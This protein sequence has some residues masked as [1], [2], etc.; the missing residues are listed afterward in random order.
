M[1][2]LFVHAQVYANTANY[3]H[4]HK[5]HVWQYKR[6]KP[7]PNKIT[8]NWKKKNCEPSP[9]LILS[10][11]WSI[12]TENLQSNKVWLQHWTAMGLCIMS[13]DASAY[14]RLL[15]LWLV[16]LTFSPYEQTTKPLI[17][18][19]WVVLFVFCSLYIQT[20]VIFLKRFHSYSHGVTLKVKRHVECCSIISRW[21]TCNLLLLVFYSLMQPAKNSLHPKWILHCNSI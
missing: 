14:L 18:W 3:C 10:A 5:N 12:H 4:T 6:H 11:H 13:A 17:S 8:G 1:L 16:Y 15:D 21:L 20:S 19:T 7:I 9:I 2:L